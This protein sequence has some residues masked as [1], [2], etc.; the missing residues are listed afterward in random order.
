MAVLRGSRSKNVPK[1][2]VPWGDRETLSCREKPIALPRPPPSCRA[3]SETSTYI[4]SRDSYVAFL[5]YGCARDRHMT[6]KGGAQEIDIFKSPRIR[7]FGVLIASIDPG[8]GPYKFTALKS[9]WKWSEYGATRRPCVRCGRASSAR[10][11]LP[12]KRHIGISRRYECR[13][14][15]PR[16]IRWWWSR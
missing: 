10:V 2:R 14:F 16:R 1:T 15:S 13:G 11:P 3:W 4:A 9:T 7:C 8:K 12:Q 5:R 6:Y